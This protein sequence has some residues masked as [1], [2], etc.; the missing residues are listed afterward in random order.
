[1]KTVAAAITSFL[2]APTVTTGFLGHYPATHARSATVVSKSS[3]TSD[4]EDGIIRSVA[5]VGIPQQEPLEAQQEDPEDCRLPTQR[6]KTMSESIPFLKCPAVLVESNLAGNVGFDPLGFASSE[7]NLLDYREAEIKHARLAMLAAIG[8]PVSELE[9]RNIAEYFH[10]PSVLDNGDRVPSILNGGLERIDPR[11]WGFC[12]GLTAAIDLYG[13][14]KSRRGSADYFPGNIG[15]DPLNLFPPDRE[16]RE[17][18]KLAE[19]KH[20]RVAM[21]GVVGYVFEEYVTKAAVVDDTP[22]LFQ[23]ITETLE[24]VVS[25]VVSATLLL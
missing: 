24:E 23:P 13:V 1:M 7:E 4:P 20:G 12:L 6:G 8:W 16:G 18:M 2:L 15:F 9:D 5:G 14:S 21:L 17:K 19:I 3:T 11:F 25:E 10:A 22:I